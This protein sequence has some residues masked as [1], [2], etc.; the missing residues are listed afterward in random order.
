MHS[1]VPHFDIP[2][3]FRLFPDGMAA[4][5]NEQDTLDDM[6]STIQVILRT[7]LGFRPEKPEFGVHDQTFVQRVN[8]QQYLDAVSKWET[9]VDAELGDVPGAVQDLVQTAEL[10][11]RERAVV[12]TPEATGSVE[13]G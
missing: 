7:P 5:T 10:Q 12:A 8:S 13:E 1:K 11:I 2:F 4:A 9:R 3:H 6:G